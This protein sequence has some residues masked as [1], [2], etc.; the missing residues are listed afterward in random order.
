[1]FIICEKNK[2]GEKYANCQSTALAIY[3]HTT[4]IGCDGCC[5][6]NFKKKKQTQV[7]GIDEF[8]VETESAK[9]PWNQI[10]WISMS[11]TRNSVF[12]EFVLEIRKKKKKGFFLYNSW[13]N[14]FTLKYF[15]GLDTEM[16]SGMAELK[17]QK[18]EEE[19]NKKVIKKLQTL[20]GLKQF[21]EIEQFGTCV[22]F[23]SLILSG[24][25]EDFHFKFNYVCD[26]FNEQFKDLKHSNQ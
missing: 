17:I 15:L 11:D 20:C 5:F 6:K 4:D 13:A 2:D 12:H 22:V 9:F 7:T 10:C 24:G 16:R 8:I 14:L 23:F 21:R 26:A 1:M 25:D 19:N 18:A 3:M